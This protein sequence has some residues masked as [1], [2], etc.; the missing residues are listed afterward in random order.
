MKCSQC[1][2]E[3][4]NERFCTECGA[5]L[6]AEIE[7]KPATAELSDVIEAELDA[8][9]SDLEYIEETE[10]VGEP[11][12]IEDD[13]EEEKD[14]TVKDA[15]ENLEKYEQGTI[16]HPDDK[17]K[18]KSNFWCPKNPMLWSFLW[19]LAFGVVLG[20]LT[21]VFFN[22]DLGGT[23]IAF[24]ISFAI[25]TAGVLAI[26]F[27]YYFPASLTL[28]RLLKGKG[29]RLEY[30]LKRYELV[31][32]AEKAKKHNRGFYL[33]IGLFGFAFSIYYIYI[34]ATATIQTTLM[35]M[36][37]IFSLCVFAIFALLFFLMPKL[38]YRRMME[39]GSRVIIGN[40]SV[41]YG[42][43][44]YHWHGIQPEATFGNLNTKRH[45]LELTFT[46][47]LKNG[48]T[49]R[50]KVTVYAPDS[51]IKDIS[52]L[53]KEYEKSAKKYREKQAKYS[54]ISESKKD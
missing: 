54:V 31:D 34:L 28:D 53:L 2:A 52:K 33:A 25:F 27:A 16:T 47:E 24:G 13:I 8:E 18:S 49:K 7:N 40:K 21:A 11:E 36:S 5:A 50:R 19:L 6:E 1:G 48:G 43:N 37:L 15:L 4:Q 9:S 30:R 39:N 45:E 23:Q 46:Q 10:T 44:Y 42:G 38:N 3:S 12:N 35:W 26:D 41:Y 20:I 17:P 51:A 29:T 32:L 14:E 22:T